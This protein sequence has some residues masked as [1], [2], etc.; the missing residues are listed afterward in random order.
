MKKIL[1]SIL[2]LAVLI[3]LLT[4]VAYAYTRDIGSYDYY[5]GMYEGYWD[6]PTVRDKYNSNV[7]AVDNVDRC[8]Q[9][10]YGP[11]TYYTAVYII[12]PKY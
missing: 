12:E 2:C 1:L 5:T 6:F 11:I 9:V 3:S 4:G 7:N 8:E 10:E